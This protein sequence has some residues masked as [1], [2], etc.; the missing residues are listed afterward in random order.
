MQP[1][2]SCP[3][4]IPLSWHL[5]LHKELEKPY[6]QELAVFLEEERQV[7]C[8]IFP[9]EEQVF[10]SL[11]QTPY[12]KTRVVIVGQDPYHGPGQAHGL[13]FSVTKGVRTPPSLR[14]IYKEL[15]SDL[16]LPPPSHGCLLPW[17]RQGVLLLNATLTV[18]QGKPKSHYGR[19]WERFTDSILAA[20]AEKQD[21]I[22]FLLWGRSAKDKV[23]AVL[24]N[25]PTQHHCILTAAHPSPLSAHNGFFGCRHFSKTNS[26]LRSRELPPID[27]SLES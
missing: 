13:S 7:H 14:N 21:P 3:F 4:D 11:H 5:P 20:V 25:Y 26:F 22:V 24:Q 9:P 12:E 15:Q 27:W 10:N 16:A 18:R 23:E 19:G 8:P 2:A 17:A 1:T 6:L